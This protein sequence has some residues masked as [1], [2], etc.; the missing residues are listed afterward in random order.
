MGRP[1]ANNP[2]SI[3]IKVRVDEETNKKLLAFCEKYSLTRAEVIR[4]G[5]LELLSKEK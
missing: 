3:D 2:K 1:K 5:L 4:K